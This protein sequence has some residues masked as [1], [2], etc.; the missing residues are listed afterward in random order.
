[1][2]FEQ[3]NHGKKINL[4]DAGVGRSNWALPDDN[5]ATRQGREAISPADEQT[6]PS[7]V[8]SRT[9]R[10][11]FKGVEVNLLLPV[12]IDSKELARLT[13]ISCRSLERLR[14][15]G[16]IPFHKIGP[17]MIRYRFDEVLAAL[18][19]TKVSPRPFARRK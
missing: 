6:R 12:L 4:Q 9:G 13:T 10:S 17:R 14:H 18:E 1:M 11:F 19:R 5:Q 7:P 2:G 3:Q 15:D 8:P 16:V